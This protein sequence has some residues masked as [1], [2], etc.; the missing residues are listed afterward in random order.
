MQV[1]KKLEI[2]NRKNS[3]FNVSESSHNGINRNADKKRSRIK[4]D[5]K[6]GNKKAIVDGITFDSYKEAN[7]YDVLKY[8]EIAGE[9]TDLKLQPRFELQPAFEK[10]G[11]HYRKIE[12]VADFQYKDDTGK[13]YVIDAKGFR[14]DVYRLKKKLFEYRYPELEILEV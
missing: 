11:K 13:V 8:Q 2:A 9:I 6:F 4:T 5:S 12:Y 14:T 3:R 7:I 10:N 1:K